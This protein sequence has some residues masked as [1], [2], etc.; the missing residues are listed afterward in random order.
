ME[1]S[2]QWLGRMDVT[3]VQGV[4]VSACPLI[5]PPMPRIL[6]IKIAFKHALWIKSLLQPIQSHYVTLKY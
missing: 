1:M 4:V 5:L 2:L 3:V 6:S